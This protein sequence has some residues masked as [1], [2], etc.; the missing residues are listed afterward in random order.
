MP[1]PTIHKDTICAVIGYGSWATAIVKILL[2]NASTVRWHI[3]NPEVR[4]HLLQHHTNPKYLSQVHFPTDRL[5]ITDDIRTAVRDSG[6]IIFAVPSA[7]L[8]LT[9]EPLDHTALDGKFIVSAIKGIVPDGYLTVAEWFNQRYNVPFDRIG[10]I[11]GPCHAEEV[12]LERLSYLTMVCKDPGI[13]RLLGD[14]FANDHIRITTS[15]DIY[16]AEYASVLKNIYA[17]AVG[18]AH[19]LS[20]GDNFLSVL[21]C[22]SAQEME[23]FLTQTFAAPRNICNSAYLGDLLVTCYS[24]FSRN[25]TFGV[26]IGKGYSVRN[27]QME[28]NM[29]AEGYYAA[30]C[31]HRLRSRFGIEMPIAEAVY[32]ILYERKNPNTELKN[33]LDQLK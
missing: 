28:M 3:R 29:I 32:R 26:M 7:F 24:Q 33:I 30:D 18:I 1:H 11:T 10:I 17:I 31:I 8:G 22:N 2:E 6:V 19:G 20:Y 23:H 16:G 5:S 21:I 15:T 25:R 27:A 14:K 12:A 4:A 13:A 9:I